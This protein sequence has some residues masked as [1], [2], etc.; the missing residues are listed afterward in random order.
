MVEGFVVNNSGRFRHIFKMNIS[1]GSK[2]S[3]SA[4]WEIYKGKCGCDFDHRFLEWL[5]ENKIPDGSGFD[6]VVESI[7]KVVDDSQ[8]GES[9]ETLDED[10]SDVAEDAEGDY[11]PG[12]TSVSKITARQ[13]AGLK[14][15]DNPRS[16]INQVLSIH[17][18]RRALTLTKDRAG[19]ETLTRLIRNRI[20]HLHTRGLNE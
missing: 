9:N 6:F 19:K 10:T 8:I 1:P 16:V 7:N 12:K 2:I 15:R 17:K 13:I 5:K 14:T 20:D 11:I 18:L 4:L 3:F